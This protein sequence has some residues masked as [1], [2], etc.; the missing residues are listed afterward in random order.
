MN[1][2]LLFGTVSLV[3]EVVTDM[4]D[5]DGDFYVIPYNKN[6]YSRAVSPTR[7][8]AYAIIKDYIEYLEDIKDTYRDVR[9]ELIVVVPDIPPTI[10]T[11]AETVGFD[12]ARAYFYKRLPMGTIPLRLTK[13]S[14]AIAED[15]KTIIALAE[16]I[17]DQKTIS[18][19]W[20]GI[21]LN[22]LPK[23]VKEF[24]S[25]DFEQ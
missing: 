25:N 19:S 14:T 16:T 21:A 24:I 17:C 5:E 22:Q 9:D 8:E 2:V 10:I 6:I 18:K 7:L 12:E 15:E 20:V 13:S 11:A 1:S 23:A 3:D 4:I